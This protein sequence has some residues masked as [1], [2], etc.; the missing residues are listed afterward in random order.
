MRRGWGGART[1]APQSMPGRTRS[2]HRT[3]RGPAQLV[4]SR[5]SQC[6]ELSSQLPP[7]PVPGFCAPRQVSGTPAIR[8][9]I[10]ALT[11]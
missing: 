8:D 9:L 2:L 5:G 3:P 1:V 10:F 6:P 4:L 7:R 11:A